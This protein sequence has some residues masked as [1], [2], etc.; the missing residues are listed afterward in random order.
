MLVSRAAR[1]CVAVVFVGSV[2]LAS[3]LRRFDLDVSIPPGPALEWG[4]AFPALTP[5]GGPLFPRTPRA[6]EVEP[7]RTQAAPRTPEVGRGV[8]STFGLLRILTWDLAAH[9]VWVEGGWPE[10]REP[11]TGSLADLPT[12][13]EPLYWICVSTL[14][15]RLLHPALVPGPEA[16]AHLV[17]IG[18]P[19]LPLLDIAGGQR[20]LGDLC[21]DVQR[22]IAVESSAGRRAIPAS[23]ARGR[24]LA[25]FVLNELTTAHPY[26][27]DAGFGKRLFLMGDELEELVRAYADHPEPFTR[28]NAVVA[29]GRYGTKASAEKLLELAATTPDD[30]VLMRALTGLG[31]YRGRLD[32]SLLVQRLEHED[33]PVRIAAL[34]GALGRLGQRSALEPLF[35]R[36]E[37]ARKKRDSELLVTLVAALARVPASPDDRDLKRFFDSLARSARS[38]PALFREN[39]PG[40]PLTA[41]MPGS[42]STRGE[43][44]AQLA[45]LALARLDLDESSMRDVLTLRGTSKDGARGLQR[46]GSGALYA[47]LPPAQLLWIE[48]AARCGD[49]GQGALFTVAAHRDTDLQ[50]RGHALAHL[51]PA[52]RGELALRIL[53]DSNEP[54]EL[55]ARALELLDLDDH[56]HIVPHARELLVRCAA[57]PPGAGAPERRQLYL[58]ALRALGARDALTLEE[59]LALEHHVTVAGGID[60]ATLRARLR[61]RALELVR[62]AHD[63]L[64]GE[65]LNTLTLAL[66]DFAVQQ[67]VN[68][69]LEQTSVD[70]VESQIRRLLAEFAR[71]RRPD[72]AALGRTA[73]AIV[74]L[75]VGHG[76]W[77]IR[78]G[79]TRIDPP[80][81]LEDEI[82]LALGRVVSSAKKSPAEPLTDVAGNES[83]AVARNLLERLAARADSP[84]R[85]IAC[86]AL[87]L[88]NH[89]ESAPTLAR[90]LLSPDAFT[91]LAAAESLRHLTN[92]EADLDWWTAPSTERSA[93]AERLFAQLVR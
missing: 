46:F 29:L 16:V 7:G 37:T 24:M 26:D 85:A 15:R 6:E 31:N 61:A 23:T 59:L 43:L 5:R 72:E 74:T 58:V 57:D 9:L 47:L 4:R 48:T 28:R 90:A 11:R 80:V 89:R 39:A 1:R 60:A 34:A 76:E 86:I 82:V 68:P 8:G 63:G 27:P 93:A 42:T 66:I 62:A 35:A 92:L 40:S 18:E 30:V 32:G 53:G 84:H 3:S 69:Q 88:A 44:I 2:L 56:K 91:R 36:A 64:S 77:G 10:L 79:G 25:S 51:E 17:E 71:Q 20:G 52:R 33:D 70:V 41:D 81:P 38:Q 49:A 55:A 14:L 83:L 67:R 78:G 50:A 73:E 45:T 65:P 22:R 21:E 12:P 54:L 75:L 87:A 13:S 19:V